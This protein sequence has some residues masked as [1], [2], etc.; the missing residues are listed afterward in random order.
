MMHSD[1]CYEETYYECQI[2][3][4]NL[5]STCQG[6][7]V[8]SHIIHLIRFVTIAW[9]A[10]KSIEPLSSCL[11]CSRQVKCRIE[12]TECLT[13]ICNS[14]YC[15]NR[16]ARELWHKQH[17]A[18]YPYHKSFREVSQPFMFKKPLSK[19]R[20]CPCFDKHEIIGHCSRCSKGMNSCVFSIFLI[21]CIEQE[22]FGL[23]VLCWI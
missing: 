9:A 23:Q 14:C 19:D 5:C 22:L 2:C 4:T 15:D 21:L 1:I 11:I 10:T 18:E 16:E 6:S 17:K 7:H 8:N 12:C 13:S 20:F 3:N